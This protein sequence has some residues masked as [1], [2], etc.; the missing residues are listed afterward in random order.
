MGHDQGLV[1]VLQARKKGGCRAA[2]LRAVEAVANAVAHVHVF[3][4]AR[5]GAGIATHHT[6]Q[7]CA[8]ALDPVVEV[9]GG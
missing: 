3:S 7:A 5:A 6:G 9:C 1:W 2:K 4:Q 8:D